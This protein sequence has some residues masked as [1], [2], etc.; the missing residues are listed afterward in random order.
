MPLRNKRIPKL[1]L[2][3]CAI[4]VN[5]ACAQHNQVIGLEWAHRVRGGGALRYNEF[6]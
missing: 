4:A 3:C 1:E 2:H 6:L 5:L